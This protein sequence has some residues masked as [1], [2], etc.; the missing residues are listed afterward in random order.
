D[1]K[2]ISGN[3]HHAVNRGVD[4]KAAGPDGNA[5][6]AAGFDG[7]SAHLEVST[8][9]SLILDRG[10]FTFAC[11]VYLERELD[12]IS[13]DLAS[14]YDPVQRKGF[15]LTIKSNAVTSSQANS[16]HLQFGIDND[17]KSAWLDCGR[18]G[19]A[20]LAFAMAVHEGHLYAG[21]C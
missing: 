8:K 15:Y 13:G 5:G 6:G 11:H 10:D 21:T 2:D 9:N 20:I 7:R 1:A 18:P 16:R 19:K 3:G 4:L 12:G 14:L 17:K